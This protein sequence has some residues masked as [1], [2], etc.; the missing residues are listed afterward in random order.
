MPPFVRTWDYDVGNESL[1]FRFTREPHFNL[2]SSD[3]FHTGGDMPDD[4][5]GC[6]FALL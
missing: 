5:K 1:Q 3:P 2:R 6:E 4:T